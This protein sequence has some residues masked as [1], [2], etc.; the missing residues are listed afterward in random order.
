[1]NSIVEEI[2]NSLP[3]E[4]KTGEICYEASD[5]V[6]YTKSYDFLLNCGELI[7]QLVNRFKKRIEV[8]ASREL[9]S[10]ENEAENKIRELA[11]KEAEITEIYFEPEFSKV[12]IHA[13]RPGIVIG[14]NGGI[15]RKIL[16]TTCWTPEIKRSC[17][18]ESEIVKAIRRM[19]HA[20]ASERKK[21]LHELGKKIYSESKEV[22]YIRVSCLGGFREVGRSCVLV[23]TPNSHVMLDCGIAV[24]GSRPFPYLEMEDFVLQKLDA[25]VI[26]H[27]HLDHVGLL[28]YL[29]E[30]GYRGPCY[31]TEPTRDL[32]ALLCMDY[33][34]VCQREHK[35]APYSIKGIEKAIKYSVALKYGEVTDI[36]C[37]VRLTLENAGHMLG[38]SVVHLNI[39]NGTYNLLYTGDIKYGVTRLFSPASTDFTR[40]EGVI[41]E[42]TY[43][44]SEDVQPR[45]SEA[46]AN[47][48]AHIKR[49][50]A[51]GGKVLIPSFA[52]ERG[53][54]VVAILTSTDIQAP[55]YLDGMLWDATAI[56]TAY[57][58]FFSRTMQKLMLKMGKNPFLDPRLKAIG[59]AKEREEVISEARPSIIVAT[60]GM[61]NGGPVLEYLE[62][63][64]GDERNA[65]IFVGYQGEGTLGRRV[66]KGWKHV[67]VNNKTIEIKLEVITVEGLSGH[68][69]QRELINYIAHLRTK[70]KKVIVNHGEPKKCVEL[71]RTIHRLLGIETVAPKNLETVRLK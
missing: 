63:L 39:G 12:I 57:P 58:E 41:I 52:A 44:S 28:P 67:T 14:K 36:T 1:M 40:V 64:G 54:E 19:L 9:L 16:E 49:V 66:Q 13:K 71:A 60:S 38:S 42:S 2:L 23:K 4:A 11:P 59:S 25:V 68:S 29:Y 5:I 65:L 50:I 46:E 34:N 61:L 32:M 53:Q 7:R 69:P 17:E 8:R 10:D 22:E 47:L 51:R 48:I 6:V 30:Y 70:P 20:Q 27:A 37:D 31:M 35:E 56:H 45:R 62:K 3:E 18:I 15:A 43:G 33:I 55:I 26:S 24:A 21:F